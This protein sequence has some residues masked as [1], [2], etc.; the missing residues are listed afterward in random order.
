M[1]K[2]KLVEVYYSATETWYPR[3]AILFNDNGSVIIVN[4]IEKQL[5][6]SY[7]AFGTSCYDKWREI[8]KPT[9]K[10]YPDNKS[11]EHLKDC[12]FRVKECTQEF[13]TDRYDFDNDCD[14]VFKFNGQWWTKSE[15]LDQLEVQINGK[16]QPVGLEV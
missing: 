15:M 16:W 3:N 1:S 13:K 12:W 2:Y 6:E 7:N 4:S 11:M 10:P 5:D 8:K 14:D 9:W